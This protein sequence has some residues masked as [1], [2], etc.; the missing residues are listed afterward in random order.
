MKKVWNTILAMSRPT[1]ALLVAA[2]LVSG[3]MVYK[4]ATLLPG[5]STSELSTYTDSGSLAVIF[6][7]AING[8][9]KLLVYVLTSFSDSVFALR[10]SG[11][12]VGILSVGIF[13]LFVSRLMTPLVAV[14]ST[15]MFATTSSLLHA[16]RLA[17]PEMMLLTLLIIIAAGFYL[18]FNNRNSL[19]WLLS[20]AV[21]GLSLYVPGMIIF[22]VLAVAFQF[23]RIKK[24]F[25]ELKPLTII[26]IS[27]I[28][29]IVLAPLIISLIRS[30]DNLRSLFGLPS[31]LP[32]VAEFGKNIYRSLAS[33]F[34]ISQPNPVTHIGRQPILDIFTT[35]LVL[36]GFVTLSKQSKLDR[37][38][39][40]IGLFIVTILWVSLTQNLANLIVLVPFL[41]ILAGIGLQR[42]INQW[43]G[44]FPRNPIAKI[45]GYGLV[46]VT[47][48]LTINLHIQRY[49]IAWPNTE[50]TKATFS[51]QL[52]QE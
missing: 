36:Y 28:L 51:L 19:V 39:L 31:D 41:Y 37:F 30:P 25:E 12:I 2:S 13:Y 15:L 44:V 5:I 52:P 21:I 47:V 8:P 34:V 23:R 26:L 6:E 49:F 50:E 4:L 43:V 29:S 10:L 20:A 46:V 33:I 22:V 40:I 48:G 45:I 3:L 27:L 7:N 1:L 35:V 42:L 14:A 18:R 38:W 24:S 32:S 17:S 11:A 9:Y 16:S